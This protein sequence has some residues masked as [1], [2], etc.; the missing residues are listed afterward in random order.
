MSVLTAELRSFSGSKDEEK[1]KVDELNSVYGD[2]FGTYQTVKDWYDVLIARSGDYVQMMVNEARIRAEANRVA[3]ASMKADSLQTEL[4]AT[5]RTVNRWLGLPTVAPKDNPEYLDLQKQLDEQ[6]KIVSEGNAS[7]QALVEENARI[8]QG[9]GAPIVKTDTAVIEGGDPEVT[10]ALSDLDAAFAQVERRNEI[11]GRS[12]YNLSDQIK[13]TASAI[14]DL[15]SQGTL[16]GSVL[17]ALIAKYRELINAQASARAESIGPALQPLP[18]MSA[19][20]ISL[21]EINLPE[22]RPMSEGMDN[23]GKSVLSTTDKLQAMQTVMS[24]VGSSCSE[25]Q[26]GC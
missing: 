12:Q 15:I 11:F 1:A 26:A 22:I 19:P 23:Y 7:L 21:P 13:L 9:L 24:A 18:E 25:S 20:G 5:P 6:L 2:T 10:A 16:E 17:D 3:E 14:T 8:K 4:D